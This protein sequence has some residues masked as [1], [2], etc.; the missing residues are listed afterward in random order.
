MKS[1]NKDALAV[2]A[3]FGLIAFFGFAVLAPIWVFKG[4]ALEAVD[5]PV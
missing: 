2:V 1:W 4:A 3:F 5:E